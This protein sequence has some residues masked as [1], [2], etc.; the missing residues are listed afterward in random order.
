MPPEPYIPRTITVHLGAPSD[1]SAENV[2]VPFPDYIKNVA[3]S[4]IYPTWPES[5]LRANIYAQISYA[6]NRI[7]TEW[8]PSRGYN[9]DITN[10][11]QFDQAFVR[12]R[13]IFEN[14]SEIV[15]E[16]FNSYV[17]RQG[18]IEPYFTQ[19]CNGTTTTCPGLSQWG[20]VELA[21]QGLTPY[22]ILQTYY[23][24]DIDI[25]QNAPVRTGTPS[26]PGVAL[27]FGD[28]GNDVQLKQAQ[29]NRISRNYPAIPKIYPVDGIFGPSTEDAVREF[30]RIFGLTV[31]GIIG[32]ATWYRIAYLYTSVKRLA[33]LESEGIAIG[34]LP[35]QYARLLRRG[36][37][38][39][40]VRVIQYYLAVI[41]AF[42]DTV[43]TVD[44]SGTFDEAT[45]N[46]V[47]A[48]Q[49]VFGLTPDGIVGRDTWRDLNRTYRGIEE[50]LESNPNATILYPGTALQ[51]G[52][53]GADVETLQEYL[54]FI[55]DTYTTIPKVPVTGVFGN[56]T[57]AAVTAFQTRFGLEPANGVVGF[58]TWTRIAEVY[59]DLSSGYNKQDGQ[60]PGYTLGGED[61]ASSDSPATE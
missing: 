29:L 27:R 18:S 59:E 42:Y 44:I 34:D 5:A 2:T 7:Y 40:D 26:Y 50:S 23:G 11:T 10:T 33:E 49:R 43:P 8:Y 54:S 4:E 15:D 56:Q 22:E 46:A 17:R 52:S 30:Q 58:S 25:V 48:F 53:Q 37:E 12:G 57:L 47:I 21:N 14:I 13:D 60:Y 28:V 41:A 16:I 31:D 24:E 61:S 9:F 45:E 39:D 19:F 51:V 35:Q 1:T 38:G 3:S 55:A 20:T 32:N 6:L 36:D